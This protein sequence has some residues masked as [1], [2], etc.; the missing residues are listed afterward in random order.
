VAG[1]EINGAPFFVHERNPGNPRE[2]T[3]EHAGVTSSRIEVFA[4][5]PDSFIER[6]VA[7][8]ATPGAATEDHRAPWGT[9]RQ[10]G[11]KTRSVTTGPLVTSHPCVRTVPDRAALP[12]P[13]TP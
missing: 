2:T 1:L 9:H 6:A 10:G 7:A 11:S 12:L 5:D 3:P 13:S 8:G 4:D